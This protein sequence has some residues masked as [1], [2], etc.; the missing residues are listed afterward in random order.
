[1]SIKDLLSLADDKLKE[2]FA[3]REYDPTKDRA[4]HVKAIENDERSFGNPE[5]TK[6]RKAWKASNNVVEYTS[7]FP[8]GGKTTH[9]VPSERFSD[10]LER[11]KNL[12]TE[13]HFDKDFE[14][15][16]ANGEAA[17]RAARARAPSVKAV[18][19]PAG[20][21]SAAQSSPLRWRHG[22]L[23]SEGQD[24]SFPRFTIE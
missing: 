12:I 24:H 7:R 10:F 19:A 15:A 6:G 2:T 8:I 20:A 22:R 4:K 14:T 16:A 9:Y 11:L 13:G 5:P 1:M 23:Q 3:K 21:K 17:P 18:V